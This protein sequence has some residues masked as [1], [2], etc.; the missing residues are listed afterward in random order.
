MKLPLPEQG[1]PLDVSYIYD[2]AKEINNLNTA[3]SSSGTISVIDNGINIPESVRTNNIRMYA[4]TESIQTGTVTAGTTQEWSATFNPEFLYVPVVTAT[5]HNKSDSTAGN[6]ISL[7]ISR[8]ATGSVSGRVLYNSEG[9]ID[10]V[11]N[12]VAVGLSK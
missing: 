6:N 7:S 8:I 12:I 4:T 9:S 10:I 1:Q 5:I 2:I 11:I 3:L